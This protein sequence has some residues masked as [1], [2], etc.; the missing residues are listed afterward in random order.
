MKRIL[1]GLAVCLLCLAFIGFS[2]AEKSTT[3]VLIRDVPHV[4]QREDFC[5][6]ACVEMVLKK[7]GFKMDQNYVFNISGVDPLLARGCY[8][9]ELAKTM[10][11]IG[12]NPGAVWYQMDSAKAEDEI[13]KQW[14][15]LH[16][17]LVKGIPSIVCMH[18]SDQ[19]ATTE[20]FRLILGYDPTS[21][22][23]IYNEPALDKGSYLHMKKSLFF[24]LWPLQE[25]G[26]DPMVIRLRCDAVAVT[27]T[28]S[29]SVFPAADYAQHIMS[30]KKKLD[31]RKF[32]MVLE[33][34]FVVIGDEDVETVRLRSDQTVKWA[35][36]K[37]KADYFKK[38]P[39]EIIDIF[40]FKNKSS[41]EKNTAELFN[42]KPTTPYGFYSEENHALIMNI[43]TGGGTLVHEIVHP[44][45]RANFPDCPAWLN[46]GMGSLY[47]QSGDRGGH[48][49]GL[50]NWR[51]AG[52]QEEIAKKGLPSFPELLGTTSREFYSSNRGNN[53]AQA[54]YLCYY[55]QEKGLLVKFFHAFFANH[56][57]DP[58]G[59]KTLKTILG[60]EDMDAFKKKWEQYVLK[61]T[62]P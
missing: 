21:D 5:G 20:H 58:S 19:P 15:A 50:T 3:E 18:Y 47:E 51:L 24:K 13:N 7:L 22:E 14:Q 9:P 49:I 37:L 40:L 6:E 44:Y 8:T 39:E 57:Q 59:L 53:Y 54:R 12:F 28:I 27:K 56:A 45:M 30:L 62:F 32:S 2:S 43:A 17:D 10:Q 31:G 60:E 16:A 35:V 34:P 25:K 38:D 1:P 36:K 33:Q 26:K 46:E 23:V 11:K 42:E 52:L 61:L 29:S 48:I 4:K 55:L 41:Y